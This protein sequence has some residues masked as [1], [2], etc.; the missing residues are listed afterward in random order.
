[1]LEPLAA[2]RLVDTMERARKLQLFII[3]LAVFCGSR[4]VFAE[5]LQPLDWETYRSERF[6]YSL[7]FP[8]RVLEHHSETPDG[9]GVEFS[10]KDGL[11]RL[12][13]LAADNSGNISIGA[14]RAAI[15]REFS[16]SNQL[17]YGPMGQSWFVLSGVRGGSI[18]YQK[19]LFACGGRTINAFAMTYPE[20]KRRA[21]DPV[22]TTIEKNFHP[23]AGPDCYR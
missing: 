2:D 3:V 7:L 16:G 20:E 19:V 23:T 6:G 17:Q 1:M 4:L 12:K 21:F 22:V 10:S 9:R 8:P 11:E 14:Y 5:W 13:I 15:V 18:Y